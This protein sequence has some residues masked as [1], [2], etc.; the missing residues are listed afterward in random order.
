M[1]RLYLLS[2]MT[3]AA[4]DIAYALGPSFYFLFVVLSSNMAGLQAVT[5]D[6]LLRFSGVSSAALSFCY[7]LLARHGITG[8]FDLTRFWRPV[9]LLIAVIASTLGGF[10]SNL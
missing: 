5:Q 6:T 3:A 8:S 10:R 4:S 7:Y 9:A 2:G 1:V